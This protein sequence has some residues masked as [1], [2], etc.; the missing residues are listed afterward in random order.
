MKVPLVARFSTEWPT[1]PPRL[2]HR[3]TLVRGTVERDNGTSL[4][5]LKVGPPGLRWEGQNLAILESCSASAPSTMTDPAV[6]TPWE[7]SGAGATTSG[8][9]YGGLCGCARARTPTWGA[10]PTA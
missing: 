6:K 10:H 3:W 9:P 5:A 8:R 2:H 7:G 1:C 4:Q